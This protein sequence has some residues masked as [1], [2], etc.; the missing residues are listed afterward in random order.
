MLGNNL[1]M[2]VS[3]LFLSFGVLVAMIVAIRTKDFNASLYVVSLVILLG[4]VIGRR[5]LLD[6]ERR[7]AQGQH[8]LEEI[9]VGR[10]YRVTHLDFHELVP[11]WIG[12]SIR[13][14]YFVRLR[15]EPG[16][17]PISAWGAYTDPFG[18]SLVISTDDG[19]DELSGLA[20]YF[21]LHELGHVSS[22]GS[23]HKQWGES[24][25]RLVLFD[26]LPL[27]ALADGWVP[28]AA[29][30]AA[31][32]L[33]SLLIPPSIHEASADNTAVAHLLRRHGRRYT[34]D[35]VRAVQGI[36]KRELRAADLKSEDRS[37]SPSERDDAMTRF[38]DRV[39]QAKNLEF[40]LHLLRSDKPIDPDKFEAKASPIQIFL[41]ARIL[42]LVSAP[43]WLVS[44]SHAPSQLAAYAAVAVVAIT[45][46]LAGRAQARLVVCR[47][48]V[49]RTLAE[50]ASRSA[51]LHIPALKG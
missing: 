36:V 34:T 19:K 9:R 4:T 3:A 37:A 50:M 17:P 7:M 43:F 47:G 23:I 48:R 22:F 46:V 33:V 11:N 44:V 20:E 27:L 13:Q 28:M 12:G 24:R 45:F 21:A 31:S 18:E 5:S 39:G 51:P 42:F 30:L 41:M 8:C 14:I 6:V 10:R 1:K 49:A 35:V 32:A 16:H 25:W 29:M 38:M 26:V 40:V 15:N 2:A